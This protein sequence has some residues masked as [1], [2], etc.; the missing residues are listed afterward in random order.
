MDYNP[1][2]NSGA[3][4]VRQ[5]DQAVKAK[6]SATQH[7]FQPIPE[8]SRGRKMKFLLPS[9]VGLIIL[10]L[11]VAGWFLLKSG[12]TGTQIDKSRYQAVFFTSGQVYFGKLEYLNSDYMKLT[13]VFYIQAQPSENTTSDSKN[14]QEAD[15]AKAS[16]LQLIKLGS[17]IH[18]PEDAMVISRDQILFFE[19]LK[20]DGK[21]SSS[22][23]SYKQKNN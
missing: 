5:Q 12:T 20:K 7:A 23:T 15:T 18:G 1:R 2:Q 11:A 22:I 16:D 17:E 3:R 4:P 19:N 10:A 6:G 14:P 8:S 9:V 13:D 21:V